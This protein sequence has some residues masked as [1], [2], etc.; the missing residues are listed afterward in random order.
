MLSFNIKRQLEQSLRTTSRL[1]RTQ[2]K[3]FTV[4]DQHKLFRIARKSI[5]VLVFANKTILN[6]AFRK[7]FAETG[8]CYYPM[9]VGSVMS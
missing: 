2:I 3:T 1:I 9:R 5:F 7:R 8:M 6:F 4:L